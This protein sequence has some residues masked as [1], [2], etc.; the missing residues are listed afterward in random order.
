MVL[1]VLYWLVITH[2]TRGMINAIAIK[3]MKDGVRIINCMRVSVVIMKKIYL[4]L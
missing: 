1:F 4:I 3:R 2:I